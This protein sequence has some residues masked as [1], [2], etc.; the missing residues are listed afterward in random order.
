MHIHFICGCGLENYNW[1]DWISHYKHGR[2]L[3]RSLVL[4]AKTKIVIS[5]SRYLP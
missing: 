3:W 2:G 4:L 1:E 5:R